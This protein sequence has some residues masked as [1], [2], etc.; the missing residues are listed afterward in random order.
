MYQGLSEQE[1]EV[2]LKQ[3]G[4]NEIPQKPPAP[5]WQIFL[6]QYKDIVIIILLIAALI[7]LLIDEKINSLFIFLT[8][9]LNSLLGFYQE[10]KAQKDIRSL[11]NMITSEC[12]VIRSGREFFLPTKFL[13]CGDLVNL[14]SGDK[15]PADGFL[16]ASNNILV[17]EAALTG[18]SLPI[19]KTVK[20]EVYL[21]TTVLSGHGIMQ[22]TS[23]GSGTKFGNIAKNIIEIQDEETPLEEKIARFGK[24]IG[25][26]IFWVAVFLFSIGIVQGRRFYDMFLQSVSLAVAVIPE[27]LP[28]VITITLAIGAQRMAKQKAIIRKLSATEGLGSVQI[29]CTDKTGTLTKNEMTVKKIWLFDGEEFEVTGTGY[30][31]RGEVVNKSKKYEVKDINSKDRLKKLVEIGVLCNTASLAIKE[32]GGMEYDVLGDTTEGSLLVLAKKLGISIEEV[33]EDFKI[34]DESSFDAQKMMMSVLV[35]DHRQSCLMAKGAPEKMIESCILA[36]FQK[37]LILEKVNEMGNEGLRVLG[38]AYKNLKGPG[39]LKDLKEEEN[40]LVF[41]GLVGI[42]DP[43]RTEVLDTILVARKAGIR[44]VMLTGDNAVTALKISEEIGLVEKGDEVVTGEQLNSYSDEILN[45]KIETVNVFAR[46]SPVEKY[47]IVAAYQKKGYVVAV[48][49]DGVNDA[50]ALKM[51]DVGVSMGKTGTDVAK[52]A[53]DIVITDDNFQTIVLAVEEGRI[54]YDNIVKAIKFLL[55]SNLGETLIVAFS[56]LLGWPIALIPKQILWI[57]VVTDSLP[58]LAMA[59]DPKDPDVMSK[60][61]RDKNIS[62]LK[63]SDWKGIAAIGLIQAAITLFFYGLAIRILEIEYARLF[64]FSLLVFI[65]MMV[66]YIIRGKKQKMFNNR[67]LILAV[68]VAILSQVFIL[69]IPQAREFF[70]G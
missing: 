68:L 64:T 43:P 33:K 55:S 35:E 59:I 11:K 28:T 2:R 24:V 61:P 54:I 45:Q 20:N 25:S 57:N 40:N 18:E 34:I 46:V 70:S 48:T 37:R 69:L 6:H 44:T 15:I 12:R 7:S 17:N 27:G 38:I 1:A 3:Y 65:E 58:A 49:G 10:L 32:D 23:V 66:V 63:T 62:I 53:S 22:V 5:W 16:L 41:L 19:N 13:V 39:S 26:V 52:E 4:L 67:M 31:A 42:Y 50:P 47:K 56:L 51:A 60:I 8:V 9:F 14:G 21:A 29:I 30:S 36:D